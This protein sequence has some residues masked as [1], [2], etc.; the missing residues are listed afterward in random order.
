MTENEKQELKYRMMKIDDQIDD[1][2]AERKKI[3]QLLK[4]CESDMSVTS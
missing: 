3:E 2:M 1:L 4:D